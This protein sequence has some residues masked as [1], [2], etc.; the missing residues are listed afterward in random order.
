[1]PYSQSN[2]WSLTPSFWRAGVRALVAGL[3]VVVSVAACRDVAVPGRDTSVK[4]ASIHLSSPDGDVIAAGG[5]AIRL[6]A[7]VVDGPPAGLIPINWTSQSPAVATVDGA[8]MVMGMSPGTTTITATLQADPR[9]TASMPITVVPA[10][11]HLIAQ[12]DT[13]AE[14]G[15]NGIRL[16][17]HIDGAIPPPPAGEQP[18][19]WTSLSPNV[20]TVDAYGVVFG[21]FPGRAVIVASARSVPEISSSVPVT[22]VAPADPRPQVHVAL[23]DSLIDTLTSTYGHKAIVL[24][25]AASDV[26]DMVLSGHA[27]YLT[28][29]I[30]WSLDPPELPSGNLYLAR[31]PPSAGSFHLGARGAEPFCNSRGC[32]NSDGPYVFKARRAGPVLVV[33]SGGPSITVREGEV[34]TDSLWVGNIGTG[35]MTVNVTANDGA[36]E[37]VTPAFVLTPSAMA[38]QPP[39]L[40]FPQGA[41]TVVLRVDGRKLTRGTVLF[42][43]VSIRAP[44]AWSSRIAG[45]DTDAVTVRIDVIP[46]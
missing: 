40:P 39:L 17:A 28:S 16:V 44:G 9:V 29:V 5:R 22:V 4:S 32:F 23:G 8:G 6:T 13:I 12:K 20:A 21:K 2:V 14:A 1:M 30:D 37:V 10:I 45:S 19:K 26:I 3:A 43:E 35:T 24:D 46:P 41:R 33:P 27:Y 15:G 31:R 36:I 25:L 34:R 42:R 38:P 11:V 18:V 7:D